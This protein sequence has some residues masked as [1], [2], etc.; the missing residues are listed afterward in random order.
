MNASQRTGGECIFNVLSIDSDY[1]DRAHL[2][3]AAIKSDG[4]ATKFEDPAESETNLQFQRKDAEYN[5]CKKNISQKMS[6]ILTCNCIPSC[7]QV[8]QLKLNA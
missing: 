2:T 8:L 1:L 7:R 3:H 5:N 6:P 4:L